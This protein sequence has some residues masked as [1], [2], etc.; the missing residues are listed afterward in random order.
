MAQGGC[1]CPITSRLD[2]AARLDKV[3]LMILIR[4]AKDTDFEAI[5]SIV[6]PVFRAGE[7]YGVDRDID[8]AGVRRMWFDEPDQSYVALNGE[9]VLGTYYL[10]SN[11]AGGG[12][13]V[14]NCGYITAADA[15]GR[16]VARSMC[17]HSQQE[18]RRLGYKAMQFNKV[19]VTNK[20]AVALW[21]KLGFEI[22]GTVPKVFEHPTE[23]FV[24]AH[25]M[26]KWLG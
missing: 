10:R 3:A 24:A 6:K 9:T 19:V 7:T 20:G 22:V 23:G 14:C 12:A 11:G 17:E 8:E 16:G 18:A 26:Y 21:R 4:P 5:W 2:R 1:G 13:H 15:Q 25:I